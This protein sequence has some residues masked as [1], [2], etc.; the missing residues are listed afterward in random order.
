MEP[1]NIINFFQIIK[2]IYRDNYIDNKF[3]IIKGLNIDNKEDIEKLL[4]DYE[5]LNIFFKKDKLKV[6]KFLYFNREIIHN[7]L[8]ENENT[9]ELK[10]DEDIINLS[11]YFYLSL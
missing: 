8:Y 1:I 5:K 11:F 4:T 3:E 6:I 2:F 10:I 7:I 9:I